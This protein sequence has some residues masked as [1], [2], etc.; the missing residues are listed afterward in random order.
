MALA[1]GW[2]EFVSL[3]FLTYIDSTQPQALVLGELVY[4]ALPLLVLPVASRRPG[5]V[6]VILLTLGTF[7]LFFNIAP[8]LPSSVLLACAAAASLVRASRQGLS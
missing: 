6:G 5:S 7:G 3:L 8:F 1:V 2:A 4:W